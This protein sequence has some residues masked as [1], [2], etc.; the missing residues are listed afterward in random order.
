[1]AE[2]LVTRFCLWYNKTAGLLLRN[3]KSKPAT[4]QCTTKTL[5]SRPKSTFGTVGLHC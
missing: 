3:R 4:F 5:D 2:L 1:M